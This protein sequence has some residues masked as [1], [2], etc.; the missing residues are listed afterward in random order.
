MLL[1]LHS[2]RLGLTVVLKGAHTEAAKRKERVTHLLSLHEFADLKLPSASHQAPP[3]D[4]SRSA[5]IGKKKT[6]A[7]IH[8]VRHLLVPNTGHATFQD[9][10]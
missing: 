2:R 3:F 1:K 5:R 7:L 10:Y 8:S 4:L 6:C 9:K